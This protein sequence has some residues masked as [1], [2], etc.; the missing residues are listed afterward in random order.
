MTP[1]ER[2]MAAQREKEKGNECMK[3][4]ETNAAVQYYSKSLELSPGNHLVLGNRAQAY[5]GIRC[6]LQAEMDCDQA[7]AVEPTYTKA[8]YRRAVACKEQG[9]F[10][11]AIRDLEDVLKEEAEH[12]GAQALL[13]ETR[14]KKAEK[15]KEEETKRKEAEE[16]AK[17]EAAPRRKI[18][19]K[20]VE[21]DDDEEEDEDDGLDKKAMEQVRHHP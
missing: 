1:M 8:K 10:A 19:I 5:I 17:Y 20:E 6:Y 4:G 3:C 12:K 9:K 7:L 16:R 13:R 18:T 2:R 21:D 11:D 15:E 14:Q